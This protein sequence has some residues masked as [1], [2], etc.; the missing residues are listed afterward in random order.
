MTLPQPLP[1]TAMSSEACRQLRF[2]L[3]DIDDTLTTRG[4][5]TP[6]AFNAMWKLHRA[7]ISVVPV[8]GRP[9]GWCDHIARMWPVDG[10]IGENGAFSFR[11]N[12]DKR[13]MDRRFYQPEAERQEGARRLE[14]L[15]KRVLQEVPGCAISADQAFRISDLAID[16]CEDVD[17]LAP[18]AVDSICAIAAEL[19]LTSKVSSIH[20]NCWFGDFNKLRSLKAF[21]QEE[22]GKNLNELQGETVFIGDSPNDEP[23]FSAIRQSIAVS[24]ITTFLG[25]LI[26]LPA[27]ITSE[28]SGAGFSEA[29][30]TI[31]KK[32]AET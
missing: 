29:V 6:E 27:F 26:H 11:Y 24:N 31:L 7:G 13:R 1:I 28:P 17:P 12:R 25:R 18:E 4:L 5:V 10:V 23:V 22:T 14:T 30:E 15:R 2:F 3:M 32:R 8:T 9:A 20:V 16:F 21:L 19:G